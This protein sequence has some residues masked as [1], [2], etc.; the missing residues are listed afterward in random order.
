MNWNFSNVLNLNSCV[1]QL[2]WWVFLPEVR[3]SCPPRLADIQP[4]PTCPLHT[5]AKIHLLYIITQNYIFW[6]CY[7]TYWATFVFAPYF[8]LRNLNKTISNQNNS[9]IIYIKRHLKLRHQSFIQQI[10]WKK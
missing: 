4:V 5:F 6:F 3:Y 7:Q 10:L 1:K 8:Y 2:I 9:I